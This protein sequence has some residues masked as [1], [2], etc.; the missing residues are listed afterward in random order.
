M[1]ISVLA[2]TSEN[3]VDNYISDMETFSGK[4]AGICYM[5]DGYF[6]TNVSDPEKAA[7]R[8]DKIIPTG[9][10]SIADHPHI[11]LLFEGI[12]K[13][14]AMLLNSLGLYTTSEKSGRYTVMSED[15]TN[16]PY[17]D[18]WNRRFI[19]M[20]SEKYPQIEEKQREKLA[21][22]NARYMLSVF[23]PTTTMSYT[24]T[25]RQL[26]YI[27]DMCER[28]LATAPSGYDETSFNYKL[29]VCVS[30]LMESLKELGCYSEKITDNKGRNF[31][32]FAK[33]VHYPIWLSEESFN[34]SYVIK[35]RCSFADLAQEQRHRTID[36]FMCCDDKTLSANKG[37]DTEFYLP[38]IIDFYYKDYIQEWYDDLATLR[39][40]Y[41]IATKVDVVETGLISNFMLKCD[42]RLC[43]RVQ[44]ETM[45]NVSTNLLRFVRTLHKSEFM[46]HELEKH[47]KDGK[48]IPKC[49]NIQCKEP[50]VFG[51]MS[52]LM[53]HI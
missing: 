19:E 33:Q 17:Y 45:R 27:I 5:K 46:R 32:F 12:P 6:G 11:T 26:S 53:R 30:E 16:K 34:E 8:F 13:I 44:L 3:I 38:E 1:N 25:L 42:E 39:E 31:N 37:R 47:F 36:Y 52:A 4:N 43:G 9:H 10:H 49:G 15:D 2:V 35:Y 23:A 18:K 51:R 41:P 29:R 14:T 40:T 21:L 50:C 22:E 7:S 20:I 24:T 28:Y 48:I